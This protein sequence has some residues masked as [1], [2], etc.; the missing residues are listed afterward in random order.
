MSDRMFAVKLGRF[1]AGITG[2]MMLTSGLA[3]AQDTQAPALAAPPAPAADTVVFTGP[4]RMAE[5]DIQAFLASPASLLASYPTGGLP[6]ATQV[7]SLAGSSSATLEP[8]LSLL[9]SASPG[10]ISAIGAGLA[11]VA[12]AAQRVN[13]EYAALIQEKVAAADIPAL[14]LAFEATLAEVQTAAIGAAPAAD[15]IGGA[16]GGTGS[17]IGGAGSSGGSAGGSGSSAGF[18]GDV[19]SS[20]SSGDF[21]VGGGGGSYNDTETVSP[22]Q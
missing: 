18:G 16:I 8:I 10:Q 7:R 17:A 5:A 6:L 21:S 15:A 3:L 20:N 19:A 1:V 11:R 13:P 4:A 2:A 12:R 14:E 9:S 22:S